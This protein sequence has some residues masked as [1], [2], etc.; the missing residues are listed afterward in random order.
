MGLQMVLT[1]YRFRLCCMSGMSTRHPARTQ[2]HHPDRYT[3][4]FAPNPQS[5]RLLPQIISM[6]HISHI[7]WH[8]DFS[9]HHE[10]A[11]AALIGR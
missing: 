4:T 3:D 11:F 9:R 7:V 6:S 1:S 8:C 10:E 5:G 2:Q